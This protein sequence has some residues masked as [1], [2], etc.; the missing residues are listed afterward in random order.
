MITKENLLEAG[1]K[2]FRSPEKVADNI[3]YQKRVRNEGET[4]YFLNVNIWDF[5][6][7]YP[8]V[9]SLAIHVEFSVEL[10]LPKSWV[11]VKFH[12]EKDTSIEEAETFYAQAYQSLGCV[13]DRHN[14]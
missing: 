6:K 12:A 8:E 13:P 4:L 11:T 10:Y 14:N 1:Y 2:M 9:G 5:A 7:H 3:L